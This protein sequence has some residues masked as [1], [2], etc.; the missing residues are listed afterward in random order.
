M[1]TTTNWF[2]SY[3]FNLI[4]KLKKFKQYALTS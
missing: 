1:L 4:N 3:V 2:V